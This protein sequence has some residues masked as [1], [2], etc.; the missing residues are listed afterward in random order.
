MSRD[1]LSQDSI[2][3]ASKSQV[4]YSGH[5]D[6]AGA[7][8]DRPDQNVRADEFLRKRGQTKLVAPPKDG[9]ATVTAGLAWNN[10]VNQQ[11]EG[12]INRM[13]KKI[14][15]V[16]VDLDLGC[17]YELENGK[18]GCI[19]AFGEL[20]GDLDDAPYIA[21]SGDERT[22]DSEGDDEV[23][24]I[25][26]AQWSEV[27]KILIYAYIYQGPTNW[28]EIAPQ[29]TLHVLEGEPDTLVS[30]DAKLQDMNLCAVAMIENQ[31]GGMKITNM[32]EYFPSHPAMDRAYGFG[33]Q[34]KD[35]EKA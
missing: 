1:R 9:F 18:R 32:S 21:L 24:S 34:W 33:L 11:A 8:G 25:N 10:I 26:G 3:E 17:L 2:K 14:T 30:I 4:D 7:S 15:K 35:G 20:F 28:A 19:Q 22:G 5:G 23:L 29:L 6:A 13:M 12:L 31:K 27:K 16:G